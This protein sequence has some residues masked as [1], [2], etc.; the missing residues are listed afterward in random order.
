[1]CRIGK[2][3]RSNNSRIKSQVGYYPF[4]LRVERVFFNNEDA[5]EKHF[6][7]KFKPKKIR[8]DWYRITPDDFETEVR[9]YKTDIC[10]S[11]PAKPAGVNING[12]VKYWRVL[13]DKVEYKCEFIH[14]NFDRYVLKL[15]RDNKIVDIKLQHKY[16]YNDAKRGEWV[17]GFATRKD[18]AKFIEVT[19][20]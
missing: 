20:K 6:H 3:S 9:A 14:I 7:G 11:I 2:T 8:A 17:K 18:R 15:K 10:E 4:D 19:F 16:S 13:S 12:Q 5:A 1:M